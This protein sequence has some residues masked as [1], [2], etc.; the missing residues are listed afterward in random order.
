MLHSLRTTIAVWRPCT[1]HGNGT[2]F[3]SESNLVVVLL[4]NA[5]ERREGASQGAVRSGAPDLTFASRVPSMALDADATRTFILPGIADQ[6][7]GGYHATGM[8][9]R[10]AEPCRLGRRRAGSAL[11]EL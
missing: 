4:S 9:D 6:E 2:H 3:P 1:G 7:V 5:A 11:S 10:H 8:T